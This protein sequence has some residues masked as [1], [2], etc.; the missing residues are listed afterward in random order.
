MLPV[1]L[2]YAKRIRVNFWNISDSNDI[3]V[4]INIKTKEQSLTSYETTITD[5]TGT[6][7]VYDLPSNMEGELDIFNIQ[8]ISSSDN[9][10]EGQFFAS[11]EIWEGESY[12]TLYRTLFSE[13]V[14]SQKS[15]GYPYSQIKS[16]QETTGNKKTIMVSSDSFTN[17][18]YRL[19]EIDTVFYTGEEDG[20]S[21]F[22][23]ELSTQSNGIQQALKIVNVNFAQ[24]SSFQGTFSNNINELNFT[25]NN[26]IIH[27]NSSLQK[28]TMLY[29]DI[30]SVI[31]SGTGTIQSATL[32]IN[33]T[34]KIRI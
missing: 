23:L 2:D 8:I 12:D 16:P 24:S 22:Y 5:T 4:K 25:D 34:E 3:L 26:G 6:K 30:L 21:S 7:T 32:R 28:T 14:T 9:I 19:L 15:I 27:F 10:N 17:T 29:S 20:T 11:A 18:K 13:Y 1:N 31:S 33:F